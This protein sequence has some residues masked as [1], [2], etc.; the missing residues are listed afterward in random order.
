MRP[1][2]NNSRLLP[3]IFTRIFFIGSRPAGVSAENS[4]VSTVQPYDFNSQSCTPATCAIAGEPA[5]RGPKLTCFSTCSYARGRQI[6]RSFSG[7]G[8]FALPA[9]GFSRHRAHKRRL[10]GVR[11]GRSLPGRLA[12]LAC[13][14]SSRPQYRRKQHTPRPDFACKLIPVLP[15]FPLPR[16]LA[17][18]FLLPPPLSPKRQSPQNTI[19]PSAA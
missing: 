13:R 5:A 16:A 2:Q 11:A 6:R 4:S 18:L 19:P 15:P 12:G 9:G 14:T 17:S 7:A 8:A 10:P 1:Q 3:G